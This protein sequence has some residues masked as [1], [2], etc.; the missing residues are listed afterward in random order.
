MTSVIGEE[1]VRT[2]YKRGQRKLVV[3]PEA[4]V[5]PQALDAVGRLGMRILR[6]PETPA[7]PLSSTPGRALSRTLYRRHPGF[8]PAVRH[9]N[10]RPTRITKVAVLGAGG[11]GAAFASLVAASDAAAHVVLVDLLP[12]LAE[13][14]A[15][16]LQHAASMMTTSTVLSGS[17]DRSAIVEADVVV[18][19][20]ETP[21]IAGRESLLLGEVHLA[22]EAI[23]RHTPDAVVIF[24]GWP[25]EVFV[26]ELLR[27]GNFAPERVLGTGATLA[28]SRLS[29][30]VSAR[31]DA[32]R[33]E[34]EALA[35]GT[36]G[37]YVPILSS[38]RIRGRLAREAMSAGEL[39]AA[40]TAGRHAP[41]NVMSLRASHG[42]S[43]APAYAAFELLNAL[44]GARPGPVPV[45]I[46]LEG[47]YGIDG[48]VVGVTAHLTS[49]GVRSVVE[50]P[51]VDDELTA[52][53]VSA[54]TV[55]RHADELTGIQ[56]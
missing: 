25:S 11:T 21:G 50:L 42:P 10:A 48:A 23:S 22:A 27:V 39:E 3:D 16:D 34:V 4:I 7:P 5:T 56:V 32:T 40:L 47:A 15:V 1:F 44:R 54:E 29:D 19:A 6:A 31:T 2:A 45:S 28:T 9:Q 35:L 43:L 52:L 41:E 18:V 14:V 53:R 30:A 38:T 20:P 33:L 51:L 36:H 17:T 8:V 37:H 55:R 49:Q 46:M 24:A 12:G 26:Q 13:S